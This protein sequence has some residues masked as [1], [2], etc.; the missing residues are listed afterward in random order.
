MRANNGAG[1]SAWTVGA[2]SCPI[3]A[4]APPASINVPATSPGNFIVSWSGSSGSTSYEL[5]EDTN[6]SF[7]TAI[8]VYTG[9]STSR[10]I[11]GKT[12]G[13]FYYRV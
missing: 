8:T 3:V 6:S 4:P 12:T 9:T 13:T 11:T 1:S 7:T 5:Q 10:W 2:N